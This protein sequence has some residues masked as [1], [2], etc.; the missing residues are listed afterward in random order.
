MNSTNTTPAQQH[1]KPNGSSVA[2]KPRSPTSTSPGHHSHKHPAAWQVPGSIYALFS[3]SMCHKML[4]HPKQSENFC[5]QT[6]CVIGKEFQV[7]KSHIKWD[8][9][10]WRCP[11]NRA[12][13]RMLTALRMCCTLLRLESAHC[14]KVAAQSYEAGLRPKGLHLLFHFWA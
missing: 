2:I 1:K 13:W 6:C 9:I 3:H 8:F 5:H 7:S 11:D 12:I 14:H 4:H 10:R